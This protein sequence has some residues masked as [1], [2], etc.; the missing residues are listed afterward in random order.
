M[1]RT[2]KIVLNEQY[3][4]MN[5]GWPTRYIGIIRELSKKYDLVVYAPG[6]TELL[7]KTVPTA[8]VCVSQNSVCVRPKGGL[9]RFISSLVSPQADSV[10]RPDFVRYVGYRET[11]ESDERCY[12]AAIYFGM[13]GYIMYRDSH[14]HG[15]VICDFCDSRTRELKSKL[16]YKSLR[17]KLSLLLEILYIKRIK[18]TLLPPD[19]IGLA[20]TEQDAHEIGRSFTGKI[21]VTRNGIDIKQPKDKEAIIDSF[22]KKYILFLGSLDFEPNVHA[23]DAITE[24]IWPRMRGSDLRLNIVGRNPSE[25]MEVGISALSNAALDKNVSD[26]AAFYKRGMF[27]I[28]PIYVGAGM[29]NKL[30]E[31]LAVG[32]PIITT[33]EAAKGID[34]EEGE[35]CLF[36]DNNDEFVNTLRDLK[37]MDVDTY[38]KM[39]LACIELAKK[40]Q[41]S[42]TI[43]PLENCIN[44][45]KGAVYGG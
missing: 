25:K 20:I 43:R 5:S 26:T 36:A 27:F 42:E 22:N 6:N 10:M 8:R 31:A 19:L 35:N 37:N 9:L 34:L 15:I 28:A 44:S 30:L 41:W 2:I 21:L 29:K 1:R 23:V 38:L 16:P 7:Q 11:V 32:T 3:E 14:R 17:R 18:K 39:S 12:D 13:S 33:R 40:Y 45:V 24:D 4:G